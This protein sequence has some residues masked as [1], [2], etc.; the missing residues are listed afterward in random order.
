[1]AVK[2]EGGAAGTYTVDFKIDDVTA[3]TREMNLAP[4]T[5]STVECTVFGDTAGLHRVYVNGKETSFT[6]LP[7]A[8]PPSPI[9]INWWLIGALICL[10]TAVSSALVF[11]TKI[12]ENDIPTVPPPVGSH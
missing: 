12:R 6:V 10:G 3:D 2:N 9:N 11:L 1:M 7:P 8:P 4:G 5:Q